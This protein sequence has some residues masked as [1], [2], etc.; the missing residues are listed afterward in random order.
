MQNATTQGQYLMERM[1]ALQHKVPQLGDVRGRGLMVGLE[2][3][4]NGKTENPELRDRIQKLGL[5]QGLILLGAG[6]HAIRLAP[7]L[8]LTS[9]D[10]T[11]A[12]DTLE[13]VILDAV[14][15]D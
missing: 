2:F 13:R 5:E 12:A 9:E 15:Q 10:A 8:V 7:P 4:K 11:F 14:A 1:K 3:V 6:S